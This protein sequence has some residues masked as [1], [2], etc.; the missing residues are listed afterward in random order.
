MI[1]F[2]ANNIGFQVAQAN[3]V[4]DLQNY[5]SVV[6]FYT[7][8]K[9]SFSTVVEF[10]NTKRQRLYIKVC[11]FEGNLY[12]YT[13]V[14]DK[15]LLVLN[16]TIDS[17][18]G[19]STVKNLL[20]KLGFKSVITVDSISSMWIIPKSNFKSLIQTLN[21][22]AVIPNGG[23]PKFFLDLEGNIRY[24][25]YVNAYNDKISTILGTINSDVSNTEWTLSV[26]A[27]LRIFVSSINGLSKQEI[28]LN[29][30]LPWAKIECNDTTS[31]KA[32]LIKRKFINEYNRNWYSSRKISLT[33]ISSIPH[34]VGQFVTIES[35]VKGVIDSLSIPFSMNGES[36]R[37]SGR[38]VCQP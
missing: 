28:I 22:Y 32:D 10:E 31:Y 2:Y 17:F 34:R 12:H 25:D 33:D 23:A 30:D 19:M 15:Q 3:M 20:S 35:K 8:L 9:L 13:C 37:I 24:V 21:N 1:K 26:P 5:Y 16:S 27:N 11:V 6:E 36:V 38:V 14:T 4:S 7:Q 18:V 29:K